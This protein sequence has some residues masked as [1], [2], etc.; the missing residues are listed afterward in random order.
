MKEYF[1]PNH[2]V[3]FCCGMCTRSYEQEALFLRVLKSTCA[4]VAYVMFE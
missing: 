4:K 2:L 3:S 1:I